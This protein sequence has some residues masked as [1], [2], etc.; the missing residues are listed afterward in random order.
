MPLI[1]HRLVEFV[2]GL[3]EEIKT[4]RSRNGGML[5]GL[6]HATRRPEISKWLLVEA[7]DGMLP[8]QVVH[9]EKSTFTFPWEYWLRGP[10]RKD[11]EHA[12]LH[13]PEPLQGLIDPKMVEKIWHAFLTGRTSWSRPWALHVLFKWVEGQRV[14]S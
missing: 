6:W 10:L 11:T 14:G 9:R 1:D 5:G 2:M 12:L 8:P 3:P 13:V 7:L 4:G